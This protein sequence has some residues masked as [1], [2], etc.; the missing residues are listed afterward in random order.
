M[1]AVKKGGREDMDCPIFFERCCCQK[2]QN[3]L[4]SPK[5]WQSFSLNMFSMFYCELNVTL[6][7]HCFLFLFNF[8]TKTD[9]TLSELWLWLKASCY[10]SLVIYKYFQASRTWLSAD[11]DLW[12]QTPADRWLFGTKEESAA[13]FALAGP[14]QSGTGSPRS[15]PW[16]LNQPWVRKC[17]K[18][19]NENAHGRHL[20]PAIWDVRKTH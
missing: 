16:K 2:T 15:S 9:W 10:S 13:P 18:T 11:P 5:T 14:S 20:V 4:F 1:S 8:Y 12:G 19:W 3:D 17:R 6:V 7:T